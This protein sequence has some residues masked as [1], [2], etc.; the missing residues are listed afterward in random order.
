MKEDSDL[1]LLMLREDLS[2][3]LET[4]QAETAI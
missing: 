1:D 4:A 2:I 3:I